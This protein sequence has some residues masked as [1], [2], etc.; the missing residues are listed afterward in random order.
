MQLLRV[1]VPKL[2]KAVKMWTSSPWRRTRSTRW[3][4]WR[5]WWAIELGRAGGWTTGGKWV[6][7]W[8][9]Y[10]CHAW[11][12]TLGKSKSVSQ[13]TVIHFPSFSSPPLILF[14]HSLYMRSGFGGWLSEV[15]GETQFWQIWL[16]LLKGSLAAEFN[17][18]NIGLL[19]RDGRW[20]MGMGLGGGLIWIS[21]F[22]DIRCGTWYFWWTVP[23]K[24]MCKWPKIG[25]IDSFFWHTYQHASTRP[26]ITNIH[27][28]FSFL[29]M[30]EI[31]R[32]GKVI[33]FL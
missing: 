15:G 7:N 17:P 3:R 28:I 33:S 19:P 5:L 23:K 20:D 26:E 29:I 22:G 10:F 16:N 24:Q 32:S 18:W 12:S 25:L 2:R 4:K 27:L 13:N 14:P 8:N 6:S 11:I 21:L 9:P 31:S 30:K 1:Y